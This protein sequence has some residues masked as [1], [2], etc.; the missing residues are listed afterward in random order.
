MT[1]DFQFLALV[2]CSVMGW[3]LKE[4]F[5]LS[6]AQFCYISSEVRH[7][8]Y[9]RGKNET[10]YS[11]CAALG[12]KKVQQDFLK[13]AGEFVIQNNQPENL[14]YS[15]EDLRAAEKRMREMVKPDVETG[16][17]TTENEH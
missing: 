8:Q 15:E 14:N 3:T 2:I 17:E 6:W 16:K 1:V 11:I 4:V 12:D 5:S 10:F 13:S 9:M 7:L